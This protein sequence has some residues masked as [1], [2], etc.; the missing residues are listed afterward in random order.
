MTDTRPAPIGYRDRWFLICDSAL[1]VVRALFSLE[2]IVE[3]FHGS[4]SDIGGLAIITFLVVL[5]ISGAVL[6]AKSR[7]L[8]TQLGVAALLFVFVSL[9]WELYWM[10]LHMDSIAYGDL[11]MTCLIV[12]ARVAWSAF[13]AFVLYRAGESPKLTA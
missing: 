9:C 13:Y 5:T 3:Q 11:A 1:C 12:P 4:A 6:L 10:W 2:Q 7:R 8:G